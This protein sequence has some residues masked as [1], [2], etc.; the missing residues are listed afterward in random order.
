MSEEAH[1]LLVRHVAVTKVTLDAETGQAPECSQQRAGAE[2]QVYAEPISSGSD[3]LEANPTLIAYVFF[4]SPNSSIVNLLLSRCPVWKRA[5]HL[6]VCQK[7]HG[8]LLGALSRIQTS[9]FQ[10]LCYRE[11]SVVWKVLIRQ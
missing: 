6:I 11:A 1:H 4:N 3:D 5:G 10:V 7:L 9:G 2:A 8:V